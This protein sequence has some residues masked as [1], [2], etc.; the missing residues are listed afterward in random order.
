MK[1]MTGYA[2]ET[3]ET[4]DGT[5]GVEIKSYNNRF[6]DV[7]VVTPPDLSVLE[8]RIREHMKNRVSR[9]RLEVTLRISGAESDDLQVDT[10]RA[11]RYYATLAGL[12]RDLGLEAPV[13]LGHVLRLEGVLERRRPRDVEGYWREVLP[14]LELASRSFDRSRAGEGAA[15]AAD[16]SEHIRAFRQALAVVD[17]RQ[18][19]IEAHVQDT[20]RTR[21]REVLGDDMDLRRVYE[22]AAMLLVRFS[23]RE[24]LSRLTSHL[25]AFSEGLTADGPVGKR[26]DFLAQEMLRE[27]NTIGSK[28]PD[29]EVSTVVIDMKDRLE[30]IREQ[31]RNVE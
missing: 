11:K 6:L 29:M 8:P 17:A 15:T 3:T 2:H 26:L 18:E 19:T 25:D 28:S 4:D 22:E 7:Y 27:V 14:V 1:S 10:D 23:I 5:V 24:E 9:G 31:V 20:V 21:F 13:D 16:L 30:S 12:A